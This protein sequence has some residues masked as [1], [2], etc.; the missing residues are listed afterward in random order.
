[1]EAKFYDSNPSLSSLPEPLPTTNEGIGQCLAL[2]LA[3]GPNPVFA[4]P[5]D[6]LLPEQAK[7]A[8]ILKRIESTMKMLRLKTSPIDGDILSSDVQT[9]YR[10]RY[11]YIWTALTVQLLCAL[12][13][14]RDTTDTT[15][16]V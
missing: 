16:D 5:G 3:G 10:D 4:M 1:M 14:I 12:H 8:F 2:V 6:E 9:F 7:R 13:A 15:G 11:P